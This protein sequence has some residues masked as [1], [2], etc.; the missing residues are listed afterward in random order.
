MGER[1]AHPATA[2]ER[3]VASRGALALLGI[4][5]LLLLL[6]AVTEGIEVTHVVTAL[7]LLAVAVP[8]A[9]FLIS[10]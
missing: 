2:S 7:T 1:P 10:S 5:V 8:V 6:D 9:F 3:R 4:A